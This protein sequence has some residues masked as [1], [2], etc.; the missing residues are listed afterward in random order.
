MDI[1]EDER[2]GQ[3]QAAN[4]DEQQVLITEELWGGVLLTCTSLQSCGPEGAAGG[5]PVNKDND[6][7]INGNDGKEN[8]DFIF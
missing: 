4:D 6:E 1:S 8:D 7:D 2:Q 5:F 3:R